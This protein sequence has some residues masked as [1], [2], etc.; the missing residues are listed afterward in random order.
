MAL[1]TASIAALGGLLFGYDTSVISGAQL[2]FQRTFQLSD[3]QLEWAVSVVLLGAMLGAALGGH[4]ADRWGRRPVLVVTGIGYGLFSVWTGLS[5][6]LVTFDIARFLV[7]VCIGVASLVTPLYIS[8]MAPAKIRGALVSLNQLA[9]TIGIGAA[10]VVDY[11]LAGSGNW[12]MMFATA[13]VPAIVL[14]VGMIFLPESPRWL[15]KIGRMDE[16]L[17]NFRRLGREQEAQAELADVQRVLAEGTVSF[18]DLFRPGFRTAVWIGIILAI[19]QTGTGINTVIYY[20]PT[21]LTRAGYPSAKA[22]ILATA[23][24]GAVNILMTVV[25]IL[26]VDRVGRKPLLIVGTGGMAVSLAFIGYAFLAHLQGFGVFLGVLAFIAFFAVSLGPVL[27]LLLAEIYPIRVRG[28]AMSLATLC[29]WGANFV[30]AVTFLSLLNWAGPANTFW[31]FA[32]LS[33]V[34]L[35]FSWLVVPETK[36]KS[37]ES[38]EDEFRR[39]GRS[40]S[41]RA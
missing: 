6:G 3:V 29:E 37:L 25:S 7:G 19:L 40:H 34:A 30:V 16:A 10:F 11:A 9:I 23:Y 24:I 15:A 2:F 31:I 41:V 33:I 5:T 27:W 26:L 1:L 18:R 20:A 22:A 13:V 8:E 39:L 35:L 12:R 36:G 38:I 28:A 32:V 14:V 17:T 4:W 21:I